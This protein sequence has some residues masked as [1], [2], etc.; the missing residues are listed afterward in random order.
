MKEGGRGGEKV[1]PRKGYAAATLEKGLLQ[2]RLF[3]HYFS[4]LL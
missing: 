4:L 3:M 1:L 2:N